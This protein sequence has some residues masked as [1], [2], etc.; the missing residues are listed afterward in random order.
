MA[1]ADLRKL[2]VVTPASLALRE[3]ASYPVIRNLVAWRFRR[4][5][6][7]FRERLFDDF[8]GLNPRAAYET[9][10]SVAN[11]DPLDQL[12][13]LIAKAGLPVLAVCGEKDKKGVEQA[14]S[15]FSKV[16]SGRL[17]TLSDC[18]FLPMLEYPSQF[19]RLVESFV[20][21]KKRTPRQSL[22]PREQQG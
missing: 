16:K 3:I 12:D 8:A 11:L 22:K 20:S 15:L 5:P 6:K 9:A 10:L 14:R 13:A 17:A 7:P 18:G 4:A 1:E 19:A 21:D 2:S